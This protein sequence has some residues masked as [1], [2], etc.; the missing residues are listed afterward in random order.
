LWTPG[1]LIASGPLTDAHRRLRTFVGSALG[2]SGCD[3]GA[4]PWDFRA[5]HDGDDSHHAPDD[6][7]DPE[8]FHPSCHRPSYLAASFASPSADDCKTTLAPLPSP[9]AA[10]RR[11]MLFLEP[12]VLVACEN[13]FRG[14]P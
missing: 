8:A 14:R 12:T 9:T 3:C 2:V 4:F 6:P 13:V 1:A 11:A 10:S 7:C 5:C